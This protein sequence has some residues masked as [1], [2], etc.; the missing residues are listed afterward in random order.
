MK[1][2]LLTLSDF[3]ATLVADLKALGVD[4]LPDRRANVMPDARTVRY[5]TS[6]GLVSPP[7]IQGRKAHYGETHREQVLVVKLMQ[8]QGMSLQDI[9][10]RVLGMGRAE[11]QALLSQLKPRAQPSPKLAHTYW[12]EYFVAPGLRL[13]VGSDFKAEH[14]AKAL[15]MI[16]RILKDSQEEGNAKLN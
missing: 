8:V 4:T 14:G 15:E 11:R 9:Q 13:Q 1:D 3:I 6:L 7:V 12:R 5:Y 10:R 16:Q 2:E